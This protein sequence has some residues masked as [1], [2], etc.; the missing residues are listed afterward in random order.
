MK[1]PLIK[2]ETKYKIALWKS[3]FET[4]YALT[5]YLKYGVLAFGLDYIL[6]DKI[7]IAFIL[8]IAYA[9]V[10]TVL[11]YY[12]YKTDFALA[13]AEV[14]NRYNKLAIELRKKLK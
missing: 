3:Y 10:C 8:G 12:W 6:K 5:N 14:G 4:G 11:G 1:K 13:N 9:I 2:F 7:K